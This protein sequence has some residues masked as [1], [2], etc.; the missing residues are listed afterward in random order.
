MN[1]GAHGGKGQPCAELGGAFPAEAMARAEEPQAGNLA[2]CRTRKLA[3]QR[4]GNIKREED[5]KPKC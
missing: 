4:V 5:M 3:S 1:C 2:G